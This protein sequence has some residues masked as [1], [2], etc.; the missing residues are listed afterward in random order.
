MRRREKRAKTYGARGKQRS[1]IRK[2]S[3]GVVVKLVRKAK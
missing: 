2:F 3:D 1:M